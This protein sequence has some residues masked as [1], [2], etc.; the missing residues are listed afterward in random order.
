[1][2]KMMCEVCGGNLIKKDDFWV[3]ENCGG[4]YTTEEARKL[5]V[6]VDI[7]GSTIYVENNAKFDNLLKLAKSALEG[8]NYPE[9]ERQTNTALTMQ[10]DNYEAYVIKARAIKAQSNDSNRRIREAFNCYI[11]ACKLLNEAN[12]FFDSDVGMGVNNE[13]VKLFQDEISYYGSLIY[14]NGPY[15]N[16]VNSAINAFKEMCDMLDLERENDDSSFLDLR[17]LKKRLKNYFI[18]NVNSVTSDAWNSYIRFQ[19]YQDPDDNCGKF[20]IKDGGRDETNAYRPTDDIFNN[21]CTRIDWLVRITDYALGLKNDETSKNTLYWLYYNKALFLKHKR[22]AVSFCRYSYYSNFYNKDIYFWQRNLYW[23]S[24]SKSNM[25]NIINECDE[26][27]NRYKELYANEKYEK[28][29]YEAKERFDAYWNTHK[30]ERIQLEN[31]K[32][33]LKKKIDEMNKRIKTISENPE[34]VKFNDQIV[35]LEKEKR[36]LGILKLKEKSAIKKQIEEIKTE[37]SQLNLKTEKDLSPL[38]FELD[39]LNNRL[40]IIDEELTKDR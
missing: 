30:K 5:L 26:N 3:C 4:K 28:E 14:H 32:K 7:T 18:N 35:L 36:D 33:N 37:I 31:E 22:D 20:W 8:K 39:S 21:F 24:Q 13:L 10:T 16:T 29:R 12:N 6:E 34:L 38:K 19:Y 23:N 2:K 15:Q 25:N 27:A 40:K 11:S 1:M 9:A 17:G